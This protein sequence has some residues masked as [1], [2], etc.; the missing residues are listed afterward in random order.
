MTHED[1]RKAAHIYRD[2]G[3]S[4]IPFKLTAD[5]KDAT[6]ILKRPVLTNW[7]EFQTRLP[8]HEEIDKWW[9]DYPSSCVAV[10][11]GKI[12]N[13]TVLDVD[14]GASCPYYTTLTPIVTG[15]RV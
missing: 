15:K 4:V 9:T 13:I 2:H 5:P 14:A 10:V 6:H 12:S 8:T 1:C 11:T 7:K 3:L